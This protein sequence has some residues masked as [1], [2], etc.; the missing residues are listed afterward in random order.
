MKVR[1]TDALKAKLLEL[2][3]IEK[4]ASDEAVKAAATAAV[5]DEKL[6][7]GEFKT[8]QADPDAG[9]AKTLMS[10]MQQLVDKMAG[11]QP[12][13]TTTATPEPEKAKLP[14]WGEEKLATMM[15]KFG[16]DV[17]S[18]QERTGFYADVKSVKDMYSNTKESVVFGNTTKSG[19]PHPYA[20]Q[21][22][23]EYTDAGKRYLESPSE[24]EKAVNG[25]YVKLVASSQMR[26]VPNALRMTD[27]DK[28][29][30]KYALHEMKWA[31]VVRGDCESVSGSIPVKNRKL[32][33]ME[34]KTVIDDVT[35]GGLEVAPISFDDMVI[36]IPILFGEV[37]PFVNMV[38]VTRGRRIEGATLGNM[39]LTSSGSVRDDQSIPLFAT[40]GFIS[41]FD[42]TIHV[43][44]G[45]IEIGLDFLSDSPIDVA[46]HVTTKYGELLLAWLDEQISIGDGVNEPEGVL[47]ASGTTSVS[48]GGAAP[49]IGGYESLMFGVPKRYKN[50][51]DKSRIRFCAN[52]TTYSRARGIP[53]GA[54][55]A[56]RLFGDSQED[57]SIF[58]HGY[59]IVDTIAN[60]KAYFANLARF[61]MYRRLG[62][63]MNMTTEGR[64]LTLRNKMLITARARFGGRLEDGGAASVSTNMQA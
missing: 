38:P 55:D 50:G 25:A 29:L 2:K 58:Q 11:G 48:F 9:A 16:G 36:T 17:G 6:S 14:S 57:Y 19:S 41:A 40:S 30:I 10:T 32:S 64:E 27:H 7:I 39:T 56:R 53:V 59:S 4:D 21:K 37:A 8:L 52:E 26:N 60:T 15:T 43:V 54:S 24:L 51:V 45:A 33:E 28:A 47:V 22:A 62:L 34:L 42:T 63:T 31:G 13:P 44:N 1:I 46:S 23:F 18:S 49:T 12:T 61:R 3:L 20:G 35:S 5:L